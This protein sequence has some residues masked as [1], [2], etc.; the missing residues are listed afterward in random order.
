VKKNEEEV[1]R[2]CHSSRGELMRHATL[3]HEQIRSHRPPSQAIKD[4]LLGKVDCLAQD[5]QTRRA[6]A[7]NFVTRIFSGST[8]VR[9][10][11]IRLSTS[12]RRYMPNLHRQGLW[13]LRS[14]QLQYTSA[15]EL[16]GL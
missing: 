5:M 2:T 12:G 10:S 1:V 14:I 16:V 11:S 4:E 9:I 8:T 7:S 6:K 13:T 3:L 15:S